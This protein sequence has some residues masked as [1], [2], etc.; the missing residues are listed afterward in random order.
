[1]DFTIKKIDAARFNDINILN[2]PFSIIGKLYP[3]YNGTWNYHISLYPNEQRYEMTFP[4]EHY[5][6]TLLSSDS[7]FVGAYT[8]NEYCIGLAIFQKSCN[9]YLYL[10]DLKVNTKYRHN[11]IGKKLIEEGKKIAT[12]NGYKGIYTQAQ[13]NN[14]IACKFYLKTGFEIGGIDTMFYNGTAQEGKI[15]II[16]YLNC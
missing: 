16:F 4:N 13:N 12:A 11:G 1:M 6:Y 15:D 5:D 7:F 10:Y 14:L 2:E 8:E 9:K 3:E